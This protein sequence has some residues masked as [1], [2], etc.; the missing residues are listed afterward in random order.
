MQVL[1]NGK[2]HTFLKKTCLVEYLRSGHPGSQAKSKIR[3]FYCL[4]VERCQGTRKVKLSWPGFL[5]GLG[6]QGL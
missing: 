1:Y 4:V 3:G 6:D 2:T 5:R